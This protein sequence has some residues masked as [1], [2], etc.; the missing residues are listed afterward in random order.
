MK[1]GHEMIPTNMR[2]NPVHP[3][4]FWG[5]G[6]A[7]RGSKHITRYSE[8]FVCLGEADSSHLVFLRPLFRHQNMKQIRSCDGI[9]I[10]VFGAIQKRSDK[11]R[12]WQVL[13]SVFLVLVGHR[14]IRN[15]R[16]A[17]FSVHFVSS[18]TLTI[19]GFDR[20]LD[21][22]P[23]SLTRRTVAGVLS[24]AFL[25]IRDLSKKANVLHLNRSQILLLLIDDL[26]LS[27]DFLL[28][29]LNQQ[30]ELVAWSDSLV[31]AGSTPHGYFQRQNVGAWD[32]KLLQNPIKS[33]TY[34]TQ[35]M[36]NLRGG[37][38]GYR[39]SW[40]SS[41]SFL[42]ASSSWRLWPLSFRR[43]APAGWLCLVPSPTPP[44]VPV[45]PRR[46]G[47]PPPSAPSAAVVPTACL[48]CRTSPFLW[49]V[50]AWGFGC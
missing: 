23:Y 34:A 20:I 50:V 9:P 42:R 24:L 37:C 29:L 32:Y 19:Q 4:T 45:L 17:C 5:G 47:A 15:L 33:K 10:W 1:P 14:N 28:L 12:Q 27:L 31:D 43:G 49:A 38:R 2:G 30:K 11:T 40:P 35:G 22:M 18:R 39:A 3:N 6:L 21:T 25:Q 41:F 26:L 44:G 8:D 13:S 48:P 16:S 46:T 36:T 7:C